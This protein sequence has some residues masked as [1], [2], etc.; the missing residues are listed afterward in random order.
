MRPHPPVAE[1]WMTLGDL[2]QLLGGRFTHSA[3]PVRGFDGRI[4][5]MLVMADLTVL[6]PLTWTHQR[7]LELARPIDQVEV[8]LVDAHLDEV[9]TRMQPRRRGARRRRDRPHRRHPRPRRAPT[10]RLPRRPQPARSPITRQRGLPLGL[11][12]ARSPTHP[13]GDDGPCPSLTD[14]RHR[15]WWFPGEIEILVGQR[16]RLHREVVAILVA[17][18]FLLVEQ[19][20]SLC[21]QPLQWY[22]H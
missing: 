13:V 15:L 21:L 5:G 4:V 22:W 16:Q 20:L 18:G 8:V 3:Y 2:S 12:P 11:T 17:S 9:V 14:R 10:G 7:V 1:D 19:W 6:D